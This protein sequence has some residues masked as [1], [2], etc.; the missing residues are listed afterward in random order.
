ME[1][2]NYTNE[3]VPESVLIPLIIAFSQNKFHFRKLDHY[4][5]EV[6]LK[7]KV[8]RGWQG[9]KRMY[10]KVC[11]AYSRN[12]SPTD[13]IDV[14]RALTSSGYEPTMYDCYPLF[15]VALNHGNVK[16]LRVLS[17][18]FLNNFDEYL[19]LGGVTRVLHIAASIGDSELA[20]MGMRLMNKYEYPLRLTD[21]YCLVQSCT[22]AGDALG[23]LEALLSAEQKGVDMYA[24]PRLGYVQ[25]ERIGKLLNTTRA[26]EDFYFSLVN[27]KRRG[28]P[29]PIMAINASIT[30]FGYLGFMNKASVTLAESKGL[31]NVTPTVHTY[32]AVL[33][34]T[35]RSG[36]P[37]VMRMLSV[38]Q[39]M[40]K[41]GITPN[42]ES[43]SIL[44]EVMA[45][46]GEVKGF[47]DIDS[48][49]KSI[50]TSCSE[51][52]FR[53]VLVRLCKDG[54]LEQVNRLVSATFRSDNAMA[55]DHRPLMPN[56]LNKRLQRLIDASKGNSSKTTVA[57]T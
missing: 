56:F 8:A 44:F 14:L 52:S 46:T 22:V 16:L 19:E 36:Q 26:L 29:V 50:N 4:Y 54:D 49:M 48:H 13:A 47:G 35:A 38:Y 27:L 12:S 34:A 15:E 53:R 1:T 21:Y 30:G 42:S 40:E 5:K 17:S 24:Y 45:E 33:Y 9:T 18:W 37:N 41:N 7:H 10:L 20:H 23:V 11:E 43:F 28:L 3:T 51:R 39:D 31:F 57:N 6:F 32:N 2:F 25:Q 55:D